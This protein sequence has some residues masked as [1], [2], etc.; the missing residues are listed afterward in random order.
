MTEPLV[1]DLKHKL[2]NATEGEAIEVEAGEL[3]VRAVVER[4]GALAS[5]LQSLDIERKA[6]DSAPVDKAATRIAASSALGERLQVLEVESHRAV[7]RT[8]P[9]TIREE[10]YLDIEVSPGRM[11]FARF[12]RSTRSDDSFPVPIELTHEQC[13]RLVEQ[14]AEAMEPE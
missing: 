5:R 4:S 7:V 6:P 2:R 9:D 1:D 13:R 3:R 12:R 11:R 14:A 10:R 8:D